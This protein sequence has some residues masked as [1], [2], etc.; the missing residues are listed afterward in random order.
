M[1]LNDNQWNIERLREHL[2]YAVDYRSDN[3]QSAVKQAPNA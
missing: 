1:Q 2:Q 3:K